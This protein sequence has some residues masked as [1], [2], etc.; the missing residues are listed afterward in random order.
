MKA[1]KLPLL[2]F[3]ERVERE[4]GEE[5]RYSSPD[6]GRH[7]ACTSQGCSARMWYRED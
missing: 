7:A 2:V 4:R 5:N 1:R 3:T 6:G